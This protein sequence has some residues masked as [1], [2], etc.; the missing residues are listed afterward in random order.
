MGI[1]LQRVCRTCNPILYPNPRGGSTGQ[2]SAAQC[3][4]KNSCRSSAVALTIVKL[5]EVCRPVVQRYVLQLRNF[6]D[7]EKACINESIQDFLRVETISIAEPDCINQIELALAKLR[8][9]TL[10][11]VLLEA[12]DPKEHNDKDEE[13]PILN[14]DLFKEGLELASKLDNHFV[15]HDPNEERAV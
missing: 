14:A 12:P 10:N 7:S 6:S 15:K 1:R 11:R 13:D 2:D 3:S 9:L 8:P 4:L 5:G